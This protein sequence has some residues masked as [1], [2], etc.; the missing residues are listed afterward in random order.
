MKTKSR[1]TRN[2]SRKKKAGNGKVVWKE[3]R[4]RYDSQRERQYRISKR[5]KKREREKRGRNRTILRKGTVGVS[6]KREVEKAKY[7]QRKGRDHK[8]NRRR[9]TWMEKKIRRETGRRRIGIRI[10]VLA[11]FIPHSQISSRNRPFRCKLMSWSL[12]GLK[13]YPVL[14]W[15]WGREG[16][17]RKYTRKE[18]TEWKRITGELREE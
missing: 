4:Q 16:K 10:S 3:G 5:R 6:I 11:Y 18:R 8:Q 1:T 15:L 9:M 2:H 7:S 14:L 17:R 12:T 13:F